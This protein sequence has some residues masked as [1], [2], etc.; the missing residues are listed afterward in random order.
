MPAPI[1]TRGMRAKSFKSVPQ[2]SYSFNNRYA[3]PPPT[4]GHIPQAG[5][6]MSAPP[7]V[8]SSK[9]SDD[10]VSRVQALSKQAKDI[11][12]APGDAK[13][14]TQVKRLL[15]KL[16]AQ[17]CRDIS[18]IKE[19]VITGHADSSPQDNF[20]HKLSLARAIAVADYLKSQCPALTH[21]KLVIRGEADRKP[22]AD[23]STE[24]GRAKNRRVEIQINR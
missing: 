2:G 6:V 15:N 21:Y 22:V 14:S 17:I 11:R 13:L 16:A 19:I 23:N 1:A 10:S 7:S 18:H 8:F 4:A 24:V 5:K 12:F 9:E 3:P 20:K